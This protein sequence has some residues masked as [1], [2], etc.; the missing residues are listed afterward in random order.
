MLI[1]KI[2]IKVKNLKIKVYNEFNLELEKLW[3]SFQKKSDNYIFQ[4]YIWQKY[5]F[6]QMQKYKKNNI[7]PYIIIIEENDNTL[8][9][10]PMYV[11]KSLFI[12]RLSWSGSPFSDYNAPLIKHNLEVS[13]D[14]FLKIWNLI[15]SNNNNLFNCIEL[16]NQPELIGKTY[17]PFFKFISINITSTFSGIHLGDS[18]SYPHNTNSS[19]LADIK[20]Q[21]NR[22]NKK[23]NLIFNIAKSKKE[24]KKVLKFIIE[25]KIIQYKKTR[26]WNIF[27]I[28]AY[29]RFFIKCNLR[30]NSNTYL[31]Y[32]SLNNVIIAAHSGYIYKETC[33]YLFP[34]YD[35]NFKKYSP[36]KIL[37]KNLIEDCKKNKLS[38]FDFTS[39][40]EDYKKKWSNN[41]IKSGYILKSID[42]AGFIYIIF[43]NLKNYLKPNLKKNFFSNIYRIIRNYVN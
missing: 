8:L 10:C 24:I 12:K 39:G 14:S 27:A 22:L 16:N 4:Q 29:K 26:G 7:T 38:Y 3:L 21:V 32:L 36:G 6:Q 34:A 40:S 43:I 33:Y 23:G 41:F 30:L 18:N 31:T 20:Y 37:L 42:F 1:L 2:L 13:K 5:W 17:N 35:L 15:L 28:Q 11:H 25:K 19:L 9:L